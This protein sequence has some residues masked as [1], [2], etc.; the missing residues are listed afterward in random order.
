M[1]WNELGRDLSKEIIKEKV[2]VWELMRWKEREREKVAALMTMS[3]YR[4][5]E[6]IG[7][8][9]EYNNSWEAVLLFRV[10]SSSL[11]V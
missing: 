5:K 4:V 1:R 3:Y 7:G 8:E 6:S 10:R 11:R 2:N 9:D